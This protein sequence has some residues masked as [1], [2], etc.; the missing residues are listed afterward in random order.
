MFSGSS[1]SL[2]LNLRGKQD[3]IIEIFLKAQT[4]PQVS[5]YAKDGSVI[6]EYRRSEYKLPR[7]ED[8]VL[9]VTAND[10]P[11]IASREHGHYMI[12]IWDRTRN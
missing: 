10:D 2:S 9:V 7:L 3:Q 1:L 4:R 8:Y 12:F 11:D 5:L 6:P